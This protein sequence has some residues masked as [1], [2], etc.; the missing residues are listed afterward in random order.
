MR[1]SGPHGSSLK[2]LPGDSEATAD[3]AA[4]L[5]ATGRAREALAAVE[6]LPPDDWQRLSIEAVADARLGD[7]AASDRATALLARQGDDV[8][9]QLAGVHAQRGEVAEAFAALDRAVA[10]SDRA[11][12]P[13]QRPNAV[14]C[15]AI[16]G[17]R[18]QAEIWLQLSEAFPAG[19]A[20]AAFIAGEA[21]A[22]IPA[23]T[24]K[25]QATMC[26]IIGIL[27]NGDVAAPARGA[28]A[29]RIR[30]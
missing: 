12:R 1:R 20:G 11:D 5:L 19:A 4:A 2:P 10:I 13:A 16:R 29:A 18:D 28:Q 7:R 9:Y 23:R 22:A 27:G 3:L 24:S 26:G 8:G 6:A 21:R 30:G 15:G 14:P 17:P 25:G